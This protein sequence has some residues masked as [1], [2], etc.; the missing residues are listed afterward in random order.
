M[1]ATVIV[2]LM[3]VGLLA[4]WVSNCDSIRSTIGKSQKARIQATRAQL[5]NVSTAVRLYIMDCGMPPTT[6][7]GLDALM[8]NPGVKGW[9]GPYLA[10][11]AALRDAWRIPF[12][13]ESTGSVFRIES[14]GPDG[15]FGTSD[16]IVTEFNV[17]KTGTITESKPEANGL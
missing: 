14:A 11:K 10:R 16:D 1:R 7:Q 12:R 2:Q 5:N 15:T 17:Q 4:I 13:Y 3:T 8:K 6:A 9:D